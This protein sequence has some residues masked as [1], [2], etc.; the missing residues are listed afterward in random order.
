LKARLYLISAAILLLGLASAL[1]IYFT[2][3]DAPETGQAFYDSPQ[4]SKKYI[5]ELERF[6]GKQAVIFDEIIRWLDDRFSGKALGVTIGWLSAAV[7]LALFL[8]ARWLPP[9]KRD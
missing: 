7:A 9:D 3:S 8:F 1:L 2:A 5:R 6:G 4:L